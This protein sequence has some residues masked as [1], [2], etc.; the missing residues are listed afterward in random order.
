MYQSDEDSLDEE[1]HSITSSIPLSPT[2]HHSVENGYQLDAT[3]GHPNS[4]TGHSLGMAESEAERQSDSNLT[5]ETI[6]AQCDTSF[7]YVLTEQV[8]FLDNNTTIYSDTGFHNDYNVQLE[9]ISSIDND[10]TIDTDENVLIEA[11]ET[12]EEE[13]S[14]EAGSDISDMSS[15][16]EDTSEFTDSVVLSDDVAQILNRWV[17]NTVSK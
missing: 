13:M 4:S 12:S 8:T 1:V 10:S 6:G 2:T 9:H 11:E 17:T 7:P 14:E 16:D 3:L 5:R 15:E